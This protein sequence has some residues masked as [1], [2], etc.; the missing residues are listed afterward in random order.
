MIACLRSGCFW[1]VLL[2]LVG[3]SGAGSLAAAWAAEPIGHVVQQQGGANVERESARLPLWPGD[4]V[5]LG[6][7]IFTEKD[8]RV[9]IG[10][11]DDSL[12]S[13]GSESEVVLDAYRFG[14]DGR[15]LHAA[16]TLV[17]GII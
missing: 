3:L 2:G 9:K 16:V 8:G 15:R 6:D 11:V 5:F 12:L 17:L 1:L 13:V 7:R 10:F 4:P 14:R